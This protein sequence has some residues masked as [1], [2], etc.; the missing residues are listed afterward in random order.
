MAIPFSSLRESVLLVLYDYM[1]T[2]DHEEF[3]FSVPAIQEALPPTTSG[4]FTQR[5]LDALIGEKL[6]EQGGSDAT[7]NDLF[8][9]T[10]YGIK[11]AEDLLKGRGFQIE[12][13]EPAPEAD[14]ILSRIHDP[15][16]HAAV[17]EGLI[18]LRKEIEQ[19]N[20]FDHELD[21]N[22]DLVEAE[23]E[24]AATLMSAER[25]R[26]SRLK[27]LLLPALRYLAK[28]FADQSIGEVAKRLIALLIGFPS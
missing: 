7:R 20:S 12:D 21:G 19:S 3:W 25:V 27:S 15:E 4:A 1:L 24:A 17:R 10:Q 18:Q 11:E 28:K 13:Y 5:A 8:A 26:V 6:V 22:G 2:S 23:I 16:E 14:Q 9:L